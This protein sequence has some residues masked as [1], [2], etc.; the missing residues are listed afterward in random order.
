M[1]KNTIKLYNQTYGSF[2]YS[3]LNSHEIFDVEMMDNL[4]EAIENKKY[5]FDDIVSLD[6]V[7]MMRIKHINILP[8]NLKILK[9]KHTTLEKLTIPKNCTSLVEININGSNLSQLPDISFLTN[10]K[11]LVIS[12]SCLV[13][14]QSVFPS[15]LISIN[16]TNNLLNETNCPIS[17]FPKGVQIM[18]FNNL[19]NTIDKSSVDKSYLICFG[20]QSGSKLHNYITDYTI[21]RDEAAN[22]V[23][24]ALNNRDT[25]RLVYDPNNLD[26]IYRVFVDN[27][28][29]HIDNVRR[30][31]DNIITMKPTHDTIILTGSQTVHISSICNSVKKSINIINELTEKSYKE[32]DKQ[33]HWQDFASLL[34]FTGFLSY[35]NRTN[36]IKYNTVIGWC[37]DESTHGL[38]QKT[39]GELFARIWLLVQ[40]HQN[41][42]DF[43]ENIRIEIDDSIGMC[44]TGRINRL[45]NALIGFI[46]GI[47]VGI[48][49]KEQ[50][51]MEINN[52]IKKLTSNEINYEA[53]KK[54]I[55]DLFDNPDV[56]ADSEITEY[57]K[58]AWL[59]ALDD[60]KPDDYEEMKETKII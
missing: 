52:I 9:I 17:S 12:N 2:T 35:F 32:S 41:K 53:C 27:Y 16:L 26:A 56:L 33:K 40:T 4:L 20:N 42:S 59:D 57:Y 38:T 45:V 29:V 50:L 60:Y 49:I 34:Y 39:Y 13:S 6:I 14:F 31:Q 8:K 28:R 10:L 19:Y 44:F 22:I 5:K 47:T 24:Q 54:A 30:N 43:L 46:D 51:Q 36:Y 11:T 15:S 48:S 25:P 18:L 21:Q 55:N 23:I 58:Q 3:V 7:D 37:E 1:S